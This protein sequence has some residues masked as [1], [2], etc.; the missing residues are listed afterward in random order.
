MIHNSQKGNSIV[1][2]IVIIAIIW[3]I[4]SIFSSDSNNSHDS[5]YR[6]SYSSDCSD[7]EPENPYNSGTGHYAGFEWAENKGVSSCGGNSDSFIEGCEEY[8]SQEETFEN[9]N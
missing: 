7:L 3:I 5:N 9:C 8:L 4:Y 2:V 1:G 6:S